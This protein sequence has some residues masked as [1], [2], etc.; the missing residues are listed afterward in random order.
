MKK[1]CVFTGTRA[2]YGLL[3]WL[4]KD[5]ENHPSLTLQTLVSGSHFSPE[6]GLTYNQIV[7]DGFI[8]DEQVEMLLSS[9]SSIGVAKSMAVGILG[10][11]ESLRR[12]EPDYLV[13]LGDRYEAL[14]AAQTAMLLKIPVAHIA[15][16]EITAG[17]YDDCIRHAITKMSHLH[18]TSNEKYRERVIQLGEEPERV[19]NFGSVGLEHLLRTP[20]Y[21]VEELSASI[22]F[23]LE[24]GKFFIVTYHP[25]TLDEDEIP[26]EA[27]ANIV[28]VL[29]EYPDYKVILTYPNAD[30]GGR[31]IIPLIEAYASEHSERVFSIKS[32]GQKR[33]YSAVKY[34]AAVIGNSSSGIAEA[35]SFSIPTINIG[36]RQKGRLMADSII[37]CN[38]SYDDLSKSVRKCLSDDFR[39]LLSE[40]VNPYGDGSVSNRI[41]NVL[42]NVD[43]GLVKSFYDI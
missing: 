29:D 12:L 36:S 21:S 28:R 24:A 35:P 26:E 20:L 7:D 37:N 43:V 31:R 38:S 41:I 1:I 13:I 39:K 4:M 25:V 17:A 9:D 16:G 2:E 14:A 18:F 27:F 19:Y 5:I 23:D 34:S 15:G 42:V 32:L 30:D 40:T 11:S 6:F 8:I 3:Y 10:F 33:Y 22:D